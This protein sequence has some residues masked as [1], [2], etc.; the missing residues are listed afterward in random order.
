ML[1][2]DGFNAAFHLQLKVVEQQIVNR[3]AKPVLRAL[4][5]LISFAMVASLCLVTIKEN[6]NKSEWIF[7]IL[8]PES[9]VLFI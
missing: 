3:K 2:L 1:I 8:Q 9:T 4:P 5:L 6:M 7:H